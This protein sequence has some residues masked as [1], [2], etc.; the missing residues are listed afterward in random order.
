MKIFL[1]GTCPQS[2]EDFN[3]RDLLIPFLDSNN[4]DFFNPVV[5]SWTEDCIEIEEQQ[6]EICDV[7]LF[8]ISYNMKGVY[9]I[10]ETFDSYI[11]GKR[12]ILVV[13][14]EKFDKQRLKSLNATSNLFSKYGESWTL[15]NIIDIDNAFIDEIISRS[16]K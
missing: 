5:E 9:S 4:I 2:K 14:E 11:K 12:S 16:Y 8:V 6:K 10:A 1:G 13:I 3:Y 15:D 7:H